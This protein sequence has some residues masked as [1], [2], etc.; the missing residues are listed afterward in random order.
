MQQGATRGLPQRSAGVSAC[1]RIS[2]STRRAAT[3]RSTCHSSFAIRLSSGERTPWDR[4]ST[5][6]DRLWSGAQAR[7]RVPVTTLERELPA[8]YRSMYRPWSGIAPYQRSSEP[9]YSTLERGSRRFRSRNIDLG[10]GFRSISSEDPRPWSGRSTTL[11]RGN[12]D[13]SAGQARP[14]GGDLS[15]LEREGYRLQS[16]RTSTSERAAPATISFRINGLEHLF[17]PLNAF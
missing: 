16:G 15:I 3:D 14:Q 4:S 8:P 12:V 7:I 13:F 17:E 6:D 1:W 10:A 11:G 9:V 2:A 5:A